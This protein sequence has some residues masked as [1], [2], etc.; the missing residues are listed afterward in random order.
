VSQLSEAILEAAKIES[1][2]AFRTVN[3]MPSLISRLSDVLSKS[4]DSGLDQEQIQ[5]GSRLLKKLEKT[6]ELIQS[7]TE[8]QVHHPILTQISY[9]KHVQPMEQLIH[10][11]ERDGVDRQHLQY[12]RD[13]VV[14][15]QSELLIS[16]SL[17][18]LESVECANDSHEADM[19]KLK[20]FIQKGQSLQASPELIQTA[21]QRLKRLE[22]ELEIYRSL[23]VIPVV[24]LPIDNPPPDYWSEEDLGRIQE[25]EEY[26]LPPASNNG[27]YIWEHSQ[28]F[29]KLSS[30]ID[31]L[32]Q[33]ANSAESLGANPVLV[34]EATTKLIQIE[35]EMK[36]LDVKDAEDKRIAIENAVKAAKKLKKGKKSKK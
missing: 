34:K 25:T 19:M 5:E 14:R 24:K 4:T 7:I 6:H 29:L 13:L 8:L 28:S 12:A 31:R 26:P 23:S 20:Y 36:L 35:K 27:E 22:C 1:P 21:N 2:R 16:I 11:A 33:C 15:C 10:R 18:R 32:R 3:D 9:S 17:S 30:S